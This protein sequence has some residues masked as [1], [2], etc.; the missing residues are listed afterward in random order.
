M[1]APVLMSNVFWNFFGL[2]GLSAGGCSL[3][4]FR[5]ADPGQTKAVFQDPAGM[6]PYTN[7]I[8]FGLNGQQ[9]IPIY[10]ATD[11][12]YYI[13]IEDSNGNLI[14]QADDISPPGSGGSVTENLDIKNY[15]INNQF[16]RNVGSVT[17]SGSTGPVLL[18]PG[19]HEG[20]VPGV[21]SDISFTKNN[22][23]A[24]DE[25]VFQPFS[26]GTVLN[27]VDPTPS[28]Y[29]NYICTGAGTSES[30]KYIQIPINKNVKTFEQITMTL[31]IWMTGNNGTTIPIVF[32][33]NFGTNS[34]T[35]TVETAIGTFT[36]TASWAQNDFTFTVPTVGGATLGPCGDDYIA[37]QIN[38]PLN[39]TC[40]ISLAKPCLYVGSVAPNIDFSTYDETNSMINSPRTGDVKT[41]LSSVSFP[42]WVPLNDGTIGNASSNS[43]TRANLDTFP[44]YYLIWTNTSN[45][46]TPLFDSSGSPVGTRGAT[47]YADY[48]ANY[49]LSLTKT[50]ARVIA[51]TVQPPTPNTPQSVTYTT[52][53]TVSSSIFTVSST[54]GW[55]TGYPIQLTNSGGAPPTGFS[56][57]TTY[58]LII[59]NSTT[60]KLAS[61]PE[62]A[63]ASTNLTF[64]A[65]G[66]GTNNIVI[67]PYTT[68]SFNGEEAHVLS[69]DE[70]PSHR[71]D[72]PNP[73]SVA[74]N[75]GGTLPGNIIKYSDGGGA[76]QST[77][78]SINLQGGGEAHS[79][80]QPTAY[81]NMYMKL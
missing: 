58:Y 64:S 37:I 50:L 51:G 77:S 1:T 28:H 24:T 72:N 2:T 73:S 55:F 5:S 29:M 20:L 10:W 19:A 46:I 62:N 43:T 25:I 18:A 16:I 9:N 14:C 23:S 68:G 65:D 33:Q 22:T 7:P 39:T 27:T 61:T 15:V 76:N 42:S 13:R 40:N 52:N 6:I 75:D 41:T 12:D 11:E 49:Q 69:I 56:V 59:V 48:A 79:I 34:A 80:L 53:H 63:Y 70:M 45:T 67:I 78:L 32:Y 81:L 71:H 26:L 4:T 44:L 60:F 21:T 17:T 66:T 74:G 35:P 47:A 57:A 30:T 36:L 38:L 31:S 54:S 8:V 3:Y